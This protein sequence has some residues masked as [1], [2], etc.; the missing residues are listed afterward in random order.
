[1]GIRARALVIRID[2]Q[3]RGSRERGHRH[4][5]VHR[6]ACVLV[7]RGHCRSGYECGVELCRHVVPNLA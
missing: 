3:L 6:A 4:F 7:G 5:A 2:L 1:M